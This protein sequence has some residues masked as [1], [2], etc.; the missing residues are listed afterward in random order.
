MKKIKHLFSILVCLVLIVSVLHVQKTV[1]VNGATHTQA[2]AVAWANAQIGKGLNYDGVYGNQCV[3]LIAYYYQYLGASTPGG[4]AEAYRYNALPS[5]WVRVSSP[6]TG[7]IAVWKPDYTYGAYQ[8]GAYGHVGIV[9]GVSGSTITV[10]N[11]NFANQAYCTSNNF[12]T[13]VIDCYIRPNWKGGDT[14]PPQISNFRIVQILENSFTV[15]A[16]VTDNVGV[17][18]GE[19]MV[20]S[21]KNGQDDLWG[22]VGTISGN[23]ITCT[24]YINDHHN[25]DQGYYF[26][27]LYLYDAAGNVTSKALENIYIGDK[28][29]PTISNFHLVSK[30]DTSFTVE[31]TVNDNIGVTFG[32]FMVWSDKNGQDD[33]WGHEG[34]IK[35]DKI[36][37]TIKISDHHNNDK[38]LYYCH[39]YLYDMTGNVTSKAV[40]GISVL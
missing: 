23:K 4:N 29:K 8:T 6:Q 31:A 15:E 38:G 30:T 40:N 5:G 28:E 22:H 35:G 24:I 7:D 14:T 33:L 9:T 2:E 3:D 17:T 19:F 18:F 36:T 26:C 39:L 13:A 20:W 1:N 27:H 25:N 32:E 12:P 34:T 21:D 16:T 11:Q 37:C 10:V